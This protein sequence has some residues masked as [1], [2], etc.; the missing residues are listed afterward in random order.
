[1][2]SPPEKERGKERRTRFG[3][4]GV[5][6]FFFESSFSFYYFSP[7]FDL[8]C[9]PEDYIKNGLVVIDVRRVTIGFVMSS[10][11][12]QCAGD[13]TIGNRVRDV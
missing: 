1:M 4:C 11:S 8:S 9:L 2:N 10:F 5:F 6:C 3:G 13:S 12:A 7:L